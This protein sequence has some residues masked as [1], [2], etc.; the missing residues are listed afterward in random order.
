[1][2]GS[3][4]ILLAAAYAAAAAVIALGAHGERAR[5]PRVNRPPP[6]VSVLVAA[7]NE[8]GTLGACLDALRKQSYP[9]DRFDVIVADDHSTDAT[10]EVAERGGARCVRLD[11]S[12]GSGKAA[13]LHAAYRVAAGDVLLVTDADCRP[14]RDWVL[15]LASQLDD[16]EAGVVCG[17]TSVRHDGL[18]SRIQTLDWALLLTVAAGLSALKT[19]FTAMGNNMA[20]RREAYEAVG[21]YPALANSIT[22]DYAL[23]RAVRSRTRWNVRL[24]LDA[25]LENRTEPVDALAAVF[26]Q[27][28]RW[29]RGGLRAGP[30]AYLFYLFVWV[31]HA[32]LLAALLTAPAAAVLGLVI[33]AAA[34]AGLLRTAASHLDLGF[35]QTA[36]PIFEAYLFGYVLLVPLSLI[37]VPVITW[38][39]RRY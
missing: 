31:A 28:R 2:L 19:P 15:N 34:D 7:R 29:A 38:R 9:S 27:R 36:F 1:M 6:R 13:A 23:F 25:S 5:T 30:A 39:G 3:L 26:A 33:K 11:A 16:R 8:A 17:V 4:A 32:S 14:P 18:L 10:A 21:G 20:F 24:V 35:A 22:E 12:D 37:V